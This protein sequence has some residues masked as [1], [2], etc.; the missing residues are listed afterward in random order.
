MGAV[1]LLKYN[2]YWGTYRKMNS[3]M[4]MAVLL[5]PREKEHGLFVT[6]EDLIVHYDPAMKKKLVEKWVEEVL[7]NF[8][9]LFAAYK[10]E[11]VRCAVSSSESVGETNST[12]TQSSSSFGST[13]SSKAKY[14]A[15]RN[16][17]K[18][19]LSNVEDIGRSEVERYLAEPIYTPTNENATFDIL[20]WWKV[21]AARFDILPLMAKDIFAIPVS[22]VASESAF[23][24]GKRILDP[25]RSSLKPKT[26]EALIL[27][28]NWLRTPID[29][30]SSTLGVEE[31]EIDIAESVGRVVGE[32]KTDPNRPM[33]SP[34]STHRQINLYDVPKG[35]ILSSNNWD[36]FSQVITEKMNL[37]Q[38]LL[39]TRPISNYEIFVRNYYNISRLER[40][41]KDECKS[42][43]IKKLGD[44]LKYFDQL[45]LERP[46]PSTTT[47]T[48]NHLLSSVSKIKCY[49]DVIMLFY[50]RMNLVGVKP[51][52]YTFSILINCCCQLG[53]LSYG[54]CLFGEM[55]KRGYHPDKVT[56]TILIKGLCI[57]DE[58]ETAF[59]VFAKMAHT[60]IQPDAFTCNTLI[61]GF[62]RTGKV[63]LAIQLKS[64]MS[65]WN[66]RLN[67]V[68]YV[69]IIDTLCKGGLL[70][71]AVVLFSEMLD[72][73][74]VVPNVVV[75]TSLI[76]GFCNS[77]RLN[78][79]KR[80]LEEMADRGISADL[81]TYNS[82]IHGHC[83]HGQHEEARKCFDEMMGRGI[84]PDTITYNSMMDGLCLTGHLEEAVKLSDSM[85]DT[86]LEPNVFNYNVLIDGYCK[87]RK[88]DEA[89][90][91]FKKMK[92]NGLQPTTVTYNTLLGGLY[93]DGKVRAAN[94]MFDE[95]QAFGPSPDTVTYGT[96]LNGYC[97]NGKV[98]EAVELFESMED[99]GMLANAYMYSILMHSFF[100]AGKLGDARKLFN[101]IPNKGVVIYNTMI[102]GLFHN[103]MSL[104]A[105]K[106]IFEMEEKGCLPNARTYDIIIQAFLIAKETDR[107]LHF[108]RKMCEKEFVPSDSVFSFSLKTLSAD[109]LRNL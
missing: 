11:N 49:S 60:G 39:H 33:C 72:D 51:D 81:T 19:Q 16:K 25:F 93:R 73:P 57:K 8:V 97:K 65:E 88:M 26:L 12:S 30:D 18:H 64:K 86:G 32:A 31:E 84:S 50:K 7:K 91:L 100:R 76:N 79:A 17:R 94:N 34:S 77:G 89:M 54:F 58:I 4:F 59:D 78:E 108:L 95:M 43:R 103:M 82:I 71:E 53:Q 29:M 47:R 21:N 24:T 96:V 1:M 90:Q 83:L 45:I 105:E 107:A 42:G 10:V 41:V 37:V 106:L 101:E 23:S 62:C 68:S 20:Q 3:L 99:T 2:K 14:M 48:F 75:Y 46:L 27:L 80:L 92:R 74:S 67:V 13:I 70:D 85:V 66:C 69:V 98:E 15:G 40:Y 35:H 55:L 63:G 104:E 22:S 61:H 52:I 38:R 102:N 28:Q 36:I 9:E 87:N 56:F 6:V 109:E 44:G 5:D